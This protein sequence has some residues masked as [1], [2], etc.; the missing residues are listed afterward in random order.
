MKKN[1][2]FFKEGDFHIIYDESNDVSGY[3]RTI[4]LAKTSFLVN[5]E[6][7]LDDLIKLK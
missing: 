4:D 7:L 2:S 6:A 1:I 5:F 3:G